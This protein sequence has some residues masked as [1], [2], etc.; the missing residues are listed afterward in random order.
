[1]K[2]VGDEDAKMID[3]NLEDETATILAADRIYHDIAISDIG[4][5]VK[6]E[7]ARLEII[8]TCLENIVA[9]I[10]PTDGEEGSTLAKVRDVILPKKEYR[11]G[12]GPDDDYR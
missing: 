5:D 7:Y 11:G 10:K 2:W 8:R 3:V 1:M 4:T 9:R 12:L 6:D